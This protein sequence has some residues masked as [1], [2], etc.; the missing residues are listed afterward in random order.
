MNQPA[1]AAA[2][3]FSDRRKGIGMKRKTFLAALLLVP[4][5][6]LMTFAA[7][8][9]KPD[10]A[11]AAKLMS[12][13]NFKEACDGFS[14][15]ALDP[16]DEPAEVGNDL[17]QAVQCLR[18][19]NRVS[20]FDAFIEKVILAHKDNGLL[21]FDAAELY[22]GV[23]HQGSIVA[24]SFVR[25][26][27][28]GGTARY[29]GAYERDRVR[30]LQ[31]MVQAMGAAKAEKLGGRFHFSL[32]N[33]LLGSRSYGEAWRLQYLTDLDKL[34]D[35][36]EGYHF[37]GRGGIG[38]PVNADGTPVYYHVPQ[39]WK[40]AQNDGERWRWALHTA[41]EVEPAL[42]AQAEMTF[43]DFLRNQFGAETLAE[44]RWFFGRATGDEER[45]DE[46]GTYALQ[47]LGEDETI[48][49]LAG[50]IKRFKLPDEFNYIL[51]YQRVAGENAPDWAVQALDKL[52]DLFE[53]RR[54]YEK[55]A[56]YWRRSIALGDPQGW[57]Q[58]RLDQIEGN[59]G[60]FEPIGT[61]PAGPVG[62]TVEFRFRN[63]RKVSF[64]AQEVNVQKLLDDVKAYLKDP[65]KQ[66]DWNELNIAD[67][68]SRLLRENQSKYLLKQVAAWELELKPREHHFD[69]RITVATPLQRAGAYLV[70][71]KME[72]GNTSYV[73]M[74]VA[75]T[76]IV[77][78]PMDKQIYCFVADAVTGRPI[79][80]ANVEFF[81][82]RQTWIN[83]PITRAGRPVVDTADSAEFTDADGQVTYAPKAEGN[84]GPYQ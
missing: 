41:A 21:L 48:A 69:R 78:K 83:N 40:A 57:K 17:T 51:I 81:G 47:T 23:D 75:D 49:R 26:P 38:A 14:A 65:P 67:I 61:Q 72:G 62:A 32:A 35:Y 59:W 53:N 79:S 45:K 1:A 12:D 18:R 29:V 9:E 6:V 4:A 82:Y 71:A 33:M 19:L 70:S 39:S 76:A 56:D 58:K 20:E 13:G 28:R 27:H 73:V 25:G 80:K 46:S 66:L 37:G 24:G 5:L 84:A 74:W 63:G 11:A 64:E 34:P 15:L 31:L 10:R 3:L 2:C 52:A 30:A 50:G 54:Q 22:L 8:P 44:Y 42:T 77:R 36:E 7:A 43:A 60:R 68:G 55:S 16:A